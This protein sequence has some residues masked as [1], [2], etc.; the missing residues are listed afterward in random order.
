MG[1]GGDSEQ[2]VVR[3]GENFTKVVRALY[4]RINIYIYFFL[5]NRGDES[6]SPGLSELTL[7]KT[8]YG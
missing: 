6:N 2:V 1:E 8:N 4:R 3:D 5:D 7:K